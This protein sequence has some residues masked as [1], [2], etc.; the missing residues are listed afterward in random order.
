MTVT[1]VFGVYAI[2]VLAALLVVGRLSD[3][4]GR[5]PVLIAAT[6]M[7]AATM[8]L[9]A[10]AAD[11]VALI[12]ARVLQ[13]LATGAAVAAVGAGLLD[14]DKARGTTANAIAPMPGTA[15]GAIA[16]GLL[17]QYPAGADAPRLPGAGRGVRRCRR[18][19]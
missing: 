1:V 19:A 13:G 7:Q 11:E 3:H 15:T 2:A 4:V 14:L 9:F 10:A 8:L 18:S 6:L 12:A 5:R 17:V 16:A